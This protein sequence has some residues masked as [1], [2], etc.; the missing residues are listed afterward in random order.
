M[1]PSGSSAADGHIV[2]TDEVGRVGVLIVEDHHLLAQSLGLALEN[3]GHDVRVSGLA[4][5]ADVLR[6]AEEFGPHV[7]LLDLDLG[8]E[9]GD[10]I[11][12]IQPLTDLA[13]RVI[14]VTAATE[15]H[16]LGLCLEQGAVGALPKRVPF[17]LLLDSVRAAACGERMTSDADRQELLADLRRWRAQ[18]SELSAPFERLTPR[19]RQ[20]LSCLMEGTSAEAISAE[21]VVS[22]TTV[23][24]QIRGVLTKLGVSSQLAAVALARRA[25][26]RL[27]SAN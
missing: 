18:Q 5:M 22:E 21:W 27:D 11:G 17:D 9:V 3:E 26:W 8:R 15:R 7:V 24:T 1:A 25:G 14:V 6:E 4:S 2:S 23:R 12:L 10:G 16:R 20:V 13:A 19:E